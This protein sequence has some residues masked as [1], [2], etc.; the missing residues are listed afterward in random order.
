MVLRELNVSWT[1]DIPTAWLSITA[2][3][4]DISPTQIVVD[5]DN[6][7]TLMC[8][9]TRPFVGA[10]SASCVYGLDGSIAFYVT[11]E[12]PAG[13]DWVDRTEIRHSIEGDMLTYVPAS[14][15]NR[16][17]KNPTV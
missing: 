5:L 7:R 9:D 17:L 14:S 10:P 3:E 11:A 8:E 16:L 6:G 2:T 12:R 15:I 4:T 1:D 13:G